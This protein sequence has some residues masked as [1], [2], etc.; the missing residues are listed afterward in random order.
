MCTGRDARPVAGKPFTLSK[1]S[2]LKPASGT[3]PA[4]SA[5]ALAG[6]DLSA[7]IVVFCVNSERYPFCDRPRRPLT[8]S[9]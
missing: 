2:N 4:P 7:P 6:G 3:T 8:G 1:S 5:E 9:Q